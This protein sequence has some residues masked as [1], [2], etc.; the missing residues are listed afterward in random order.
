MSGLNRTAG[1]FCDACGLEGPAERMRKVGRVTLC[2]ACLTEIE[3][4]LKTLHV[5]PEGHR[6]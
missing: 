1:G 4:L 2:I 3:E 6:A 5:E